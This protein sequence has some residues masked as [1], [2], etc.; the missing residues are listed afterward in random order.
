MSLCDCELGHNGLGMAIR[1]CDC[2]AGNP[3]LFD[4]TSVIQFTDAMQ[5]KMTVSREKGRS[6]WHTVP[7]EDLWRMLREHVE[8]GDPIDIANF[9][10]MIWH[11]SAKRN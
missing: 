2:P 10:M 7:V 5:A 11:N 9:A 6:G 4:N 8:K 3:G 1:E